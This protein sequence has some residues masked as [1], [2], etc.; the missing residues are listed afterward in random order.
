MD[1]KTSM[2]QPL[3]HEHL[4]FY[5]ARFFIST[6]CTGCDR[7][8]NFYGGYCCNEPDCFVWFHKE[9]A[10]A[11]LE[12]NHPSH[13]EHPITLTKF[14]DINDPGY[15]YL[16]GLYMPSRG[17]NCSTCEFKVDLACGMK[18]WPPIIEHPLCHDHP[19]I[20]K[21]S[22]SSF[23]EVCKDLIH[24]QSYSCI[25]CDVYFHANCIQLSKELKH[26]CHINHPLK[27]TALDTLTNDAEK[28]CLLCSETP[29]DVCYFCS[30]CNFTTCLTCTKNPPPLVVEHTKTHQHPL[31]RLSKRISYICDVCGLKCKN[32]EHHGSYICHHCDFVIHGKCIGFP[33]V[34]NI[35]RHVHRISFTQLL[36]AG[37]SKCGVCHQS[38]T[39]YHGA[40]TC[41][42]C[43]NYAVHSDC[44]VNVTTV[45]DGVE[46]EGIPDDTK[47]LAAYKVV[48]D[49][50]INHVSHV[51][52]NLKLHKDNFVLYDHK[53]MRC[54]ACIDPVGFDSIYVCEECCFI[55]HEKC[56]NLPM[57]IKY[58]FD[59]IPYILEFENITAAKYCSLCHTYSDGFKYSAGA[60][61]ME[62]DVRCCSI[63][64]PFVHAG[65][66]HPLYFLFNSYL[67]KCN[68]CMN[69]TYKHVLRCDTCN[70]YLC[71]F[72]A[73]LPLK[74]WH[75]NDEHPLAL[76]C[77]KEASC[78]IWC[79]ICER[80]SDPSLWFY[81]CSDC[82]VIFHVRCVVGDFS[83]INV[84]ST[85]ECGRAGEIFEAVPNNYK[86]RPLCRK[87]HSRCMSSIIVK[88]KGEN[89]VYL[90]SQHCL[91][92]I[93]LSL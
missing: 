64:E 26:P 18:P 67:L 59:I 32:E 53:W 92:L 80:K 39:Q 73:T 7:I 24:I 22:H 74:I 46:L 89:N 27:L 47:D 52:H 2:Y 31:T 33:R 23:C 16:C 43:P 45:W 81:T 65:H 41:S 49:D 68:A 44:A 36:G 1:T 84:G 79:D 88:K 72:C 20:F 37:Y 5:S 8:D 71:L 12:I 91:M 83:R 82:G 19:I 40:Y 11:P 17:F 90:C 56:A 77:G 69:V 6:T 66:L 76:C 29:I 60:R 3:I 10:E 62:V 38:I 55:L 78:Q 35:N 28:T 13:P 14:N 61:R 25:K 57:K 15:C 51:K 70:F 34:I 75:K 21:R 50:L 86:T 85:I 58:F 4:L 87:C 54:E 93:S 48:G 42:V 9:C 63:S 30:I